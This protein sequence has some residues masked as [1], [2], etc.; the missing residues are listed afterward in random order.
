MITYIFFFFF[1][2]DVR[3]NVLRLQLENIN[4]WNLG[5]QVHLESRYIRYY[6]VVTYVSNL[7]NIKRYTKGLTVLFTKMPWSGRCKQHLWADGRQVI[8]VTC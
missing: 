5:S 6:F 3:E 4:C 7:Q 2:L 1:S 8:V